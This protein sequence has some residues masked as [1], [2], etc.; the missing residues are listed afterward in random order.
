MWIRDHESGPYLNKDEI[1]SKNMVFSSTI[2]DAWKMISQEVNNYL[3]A[4]E[5]HDQKKDKD[6]VDIPKIDDHMWKTFKETVINKDLFKN[7]KRKEAATSR[8]RD[9]ETKQF[10]KNRG[11]KR[12]S[13]NNNGYDSKE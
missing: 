7:Q 5:K 1:D 12:I 11:L 10:I 4:K 9:K 8:T 3:S 2:H 6:E 13:N